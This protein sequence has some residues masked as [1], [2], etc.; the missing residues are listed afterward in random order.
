MNRIASERKFILRG[1]EIDYHR[2]GQTILNEFRAG[3][4]GRITLESPQEQ[5]KKTDSEE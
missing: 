2:T 4:M 3:L 5:N 1:K